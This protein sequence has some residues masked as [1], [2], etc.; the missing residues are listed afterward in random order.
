[1]TSSIAPCRPAALVATKSRCASLMRGGQGRPNLQPAIPPN[2]RIVVIFLNAFRV[3]R[4][5]LAMIKSHQNKLR[6]RS[7]G[8]ITCSCWSKSLSVPDRV[9]V[10]T[11]KKET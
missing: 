8:F 6:I 2:L 5:T 10:E 7:A 4:A 9:R 11:G 3:S 1:L